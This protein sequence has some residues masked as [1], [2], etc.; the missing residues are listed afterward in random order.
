MSFLK[1]F[2]SQPDDPDFGSGRTFLIAGLGNPGKKYAQTRHN[3]GFMAIDK[4][5]RELQFT[6]SR[7]KHKALI[8]DG[9][10][11]PDRIILI[12]PQTFMNLSGDSIGRLANFYKVEPA[13]VLVI[14]DE[15]DLPLG[16][17]RMREKGGS[18]GHN[19]M[20]S[21]I[22]HL[23]QE[24]PRI[25]LG[26]GRPQGKM[27]ASAH[28]LQKFSS[29]EAPIVDDMLARTVSAVDYFVREGVHQA[30]SRFNGTVLDI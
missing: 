11:G 19:G 22:N 5:A 30:M 15:I 10:Q 16:T 24:F 7:V 3:I 29:K 2:F 17:F 6:L 12:K 25:R 4:I 23:G 26:I 20:K 9:R 28:V 14:Y 8:G 1:R 13:Q 21:I 18:G 27:P